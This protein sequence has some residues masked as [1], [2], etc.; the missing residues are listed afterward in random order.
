M[1]VTLTKEYWIL[2][3]SEKEYYLWINGEI[4]DWVTNIQDATKFPSE[5]GAII[6]N[7]TR[8]YEIIARHEVAPI[9]VINTFEF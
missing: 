6:Y 2:S 4:V 9:K 3:D 7:K 8:C 5:Q 1:N